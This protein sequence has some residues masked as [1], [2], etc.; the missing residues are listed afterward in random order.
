MAQRRGRRTP[1]E[2]ASIVKTVRFTPEAWARVQSRLAGYSFGEYARAMVEHGI[3]R[4]DARGVA[5]AAFVDVL[6]AIRR[7][8]PPSDLEDLLYRYLA[9]FA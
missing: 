6:S 4:V 9:L 8:A 7:G 1:S 3:V 2:T 5:Q